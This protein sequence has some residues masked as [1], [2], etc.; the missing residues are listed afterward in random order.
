MVSSVNSNDGIPVNGDKS[1]FS[2]SGTTSGETRFVNSTWTEAAAKDNRTESEEKQLYTQYR[3]ACLN[4][5]RSIMVNAFGAK[6]AGNDSTITFEEY[7][8]LFLPEDKLR[9]AGLS[10]KEIKQGYKEYLQMFQECYDLNNDGK[11]DVTELAA[12]MPVIDENNGQYDGQ[13]DQN[14]LKDLMINIPLSDATARKELRTRIENSYN[15]F[16]ADQE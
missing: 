16:I 7:I 11:L 9:A 14:A 10:K 15:Q 3:E 5:A 13:Y 1:P 6:D 2:A 4:G 8:K 12:W